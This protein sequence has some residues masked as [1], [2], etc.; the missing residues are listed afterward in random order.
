MFRMLTEDEVAEFDAK[1]W[2]GELERIQR[3]RNTLDVYEG[4]VIARG[5]RAGAAAAAGERRMSDAMRRR[6]G[7]S[8]NEARRRNRASQ[9]AA[10][11]EKIREGMAD[12]DINAEQ[13]TDL[14]EADVS[15]ETRDRL[16][17]EAREDTADET[18]RKTTEAQRQH[19]ARNGE[20]PSVGHRK[21]RSGRRYV[22]REGMWNLELRTD[23]ETGA[24]LDA[25][26]A[27]S[28]KGLWQVDKGSEAERTPQQRY[29]DAIT[30]AI[31]NSSG[32]DMHP[33]GIRPEITVTVDHQWLID[34]TNQFD[35]TYSSSGIAFTAATLRRLA[36]DAAVL[37]AVLGGDSE[38]L[39]LGRSKRTVSKAQRA[40]LRL[41][42]QRCVWP[43]C[44]ATPD[45]CDGHHVRHWIW[46]GPTDLSNLV[47]LCHTHHRLCHEGGY[48]MWADSRNG[49]W[50]IHD[51]SGTP[52]FHTQTPRAGPGFFEQTG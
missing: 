19:R 43:R 33:A 36:C 25:I 52:R 24:Q 5:E 10:D 38:L 20:D 21:R 8:G 15:R 31:L 47:L 3:F 29:A 41:R 42:D 50:N 4:W 6:L 13:A 16:T 12:G 26:I 48:E 9:A 28:Y 27:A 35:P 11:H 32:R 14:G 49:G 2:L 51:S 7:I 30:A 23:A 18:R 40:A 46:G 34:H 22:D 37:P 44:D 1:A 45:M 17:D 39:D